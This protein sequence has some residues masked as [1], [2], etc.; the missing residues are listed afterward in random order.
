MSKLQT[1][2][3]LLAAFDHTE[4]LRVDTESLKPKLEAEIGAALATGDV[5]DEKIATSLQTKR[6][7]LEMIPAKLGQISIRSEKLQAAIQTEFYSRFKTF[8][9]ELQVL[10]A[11]T[12]KKVLDVLAPLMIDPLVVQELFDRM[13]WIRTKPAAEL[14]GLRSGIDFQ[15]TQQNIIGAARELLKRKGDLALI[16]ARP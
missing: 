4:A 11:A 12:K 7:Q 1:L 15:L 3:S 8:D 5:L 2:E 9:S 16:K 6:A 13:I 10:Q 14:A